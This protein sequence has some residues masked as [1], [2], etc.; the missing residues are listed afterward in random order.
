MGHSFHI[1]DISNPK[2][3][4]FLE[5]IKTLDFVSVDKIDIP[6]WQQD[7]TLKRM[8]ELDKDP[9][10]AIDFDNMIDRLEKKHGL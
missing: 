8:A 9:S 10:K 1:N 3:Q 4:A 6:K 5:Y 7:L 2:A